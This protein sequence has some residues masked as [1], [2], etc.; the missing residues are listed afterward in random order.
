VN[1]LAFLENVDLQ[2]L[3]QSIREIIADPTSNLTAAVLLVGVVS[4]ILLILVIVVLLLLAP[5]ADEDEDE[6]EDEEGGETPGEGE[7]EA[8]PVVTEPEAEPVPVKPVPEWRRRL[9]RGLLRL[10]LFAIPLLVIGALVSGYV[11]TSQTS[12]CLSCH[13][14]QMA[15]LE[16]SDPMGFSEAPKPVHGKVAC[17]RCH[18]DDQFWGAAGNTFDRARHVVAYVAGKRAGSNASVPSGR[19]LSCHQVVLSKSVGDAGRGLVMSHAEP[20]AAGVPCRECHENVGHYP[21]AKRPAMS[22]CLR[23][24]DGAKV[25]SECKTCHTKEPAVAA[26]DRRSFAANARITREDCGGCHSQ[27]KC[28]ACHGLRMPHDQVFLAYGHA[29]LAAF[30][31]REKWCWPCHVEGDCGKCHLTNGRLP[32]YWGHT[33]GTDWKWRHATITPSGVVA[34]CGC[35][36]RSPWVKRGQDY[37]LECHPPGIR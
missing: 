22:S 1:P 19:C 34:G 23:C 15:G 10:S 9:N 5:G 28:D 12:Y 3:S 20:E 26:S 4:I 25:A 13:S 2:T 32:G 30:D 16:K 6:D 31:G 35:H 7:A 8:A 11:I 36:G 33:S 29:K 37:C 14:R 18:E 17:V 21:D 24:H 27:R